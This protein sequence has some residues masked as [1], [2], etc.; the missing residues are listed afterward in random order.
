[1]ESIAKV[2]LLPIVEEMRNTAFLE[3]DKM[4]KK[5]LHALTSTTPNHVP[6]ERSQLLVLI[7]QTSIHQ[8]LVVAL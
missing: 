2:W 3:L 6:Y 7:L 8:T 4:K 5:T 1:M